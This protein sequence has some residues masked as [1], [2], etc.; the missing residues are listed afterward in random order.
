[1]LMQLYYRFT[2]PIGLSVGLLIAGWSNDLSLMYLR[3][4]RM[5][6]RAL[7]LA[8]TTVKTNNKQKQYN[9]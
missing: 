3:R 9:I 7:T 1:M 8:R 6:D 4:Y 2:P 5:A